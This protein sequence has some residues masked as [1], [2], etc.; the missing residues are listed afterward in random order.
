MKILSWNGFQRT[1]YTAME[2]PSYVSRYC[3]LKALEH[4]WI[5]PSSVPTRNKCSLCLLKS[6]QRPPARPAKDVSS[7][8]LVA[9]LLDISF[10]SM[11]SSLSSLFFIKN[12]FETRPSEEIEK[13][14]RVPL[15]SSLF[16][17]TSHTGSVCLLV[18]TVLW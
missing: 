16:Q 3:P 6:K 5:R 8:S 18:R 10:S 14:F 4:L 2:W 11:T 15:D 1:V 9:A 7:S 17:R 12:Q 13:K